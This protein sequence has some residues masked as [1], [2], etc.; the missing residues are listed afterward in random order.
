MSLFC[1]NF[2]YSDGKMFIAVNSG[3]IQIDL[4]QNQ[5]DEKESG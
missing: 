5:N 4:F 3:C 1:F 2:I